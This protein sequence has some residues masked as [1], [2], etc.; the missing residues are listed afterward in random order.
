MRD[1][2]RELE[3]GTHVVSI[4]RLKRLMKEPS[5]YLDTSF[6]GNFYTRRGSAF[7]KL[8]IEGDISDEFDVIKGEEPDP[9]SSQMWSLI[10]VLTGILTVQGGTV[11]DHWEE[12]VSQSSYAVSPTSVRKYFKPYE[13]WFYGHL[14]AFANGRESIS[15]D[16][17]DTIKIMVENYRKEPELVKLL[18]GEFQ[19][20]IEFEA[21]GFKCKGFVDRW[22]AEDGIIVDFKTSKRNWKSVPREQRYD[23]QGS[24]YETGLKQMGNS[25]NKV[26][27][28]VCSTEPPYL[29]KVVELTRR[30]LDI[31]RFG[32]L[33]PSLI[34][35]EIY[36]KKVPKL[37]LEEVL[38]FEDLL[39]RLQW[40]VKNGFDK[41]PDDPLF[42][43][44]NIW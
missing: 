21:G 27:F 17:F 1:I 40:H 42:N 8:L 14:E 36:G 28:I 26:Y 10:D 19:K 11:D 13:D 30:D 18:S 44:S 25:V 23:L 35:E 6:T 33:S 5:E 2:L 20:R 15:Q 29:P 41:T 12:A 7:E 24:F 32:G 31:G 4:S 37:V 34:N 39:S 22:S 9:F 38:G 16:A 3:E 43:K